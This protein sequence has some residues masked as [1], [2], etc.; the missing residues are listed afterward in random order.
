LASVSAIDTN[1]SWH[2]AQAITVAVELREGLAARSASCARTF[3]EAVMPSLPVGVY[4]GSARLTIVSAA[5]ATIVAVR[6]RRVV[7]FVIRFVFI[8]SFF[9]LI[10]LFVSSGELM[11][12]DHET[13]LLAF[14]RKKDPERGIYSASARIMRHLTRTDMATICT[15]A[16]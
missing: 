2:L 11:A 13:P 14:L 1:A 5:S 9:F 7:I 8:D 15:E 10:F 6:L 3:G 4:C 16:E 12:H